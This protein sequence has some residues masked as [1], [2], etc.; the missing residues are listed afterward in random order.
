V[1]RSSQ[2]MKMKLGLSAALARDRMNRKMGM[3][4]MDRMVI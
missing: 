2:R 4:A 3:K 1:P